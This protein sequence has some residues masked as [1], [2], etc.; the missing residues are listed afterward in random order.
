MHVKFNDRWQFAENCFF[1]QDGID[2][3]R[4]DGHY[5]MYLAM[6]TRRAV[7]IVGKETLAQWTFH[8]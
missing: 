7:K 5:S 8:P 3:K 1:L 2:D 6:H 4:T